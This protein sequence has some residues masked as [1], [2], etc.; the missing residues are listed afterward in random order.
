MVEA[1]RKR[2]EELLL[3]VVMVAFNGI[4]SQI[5]IPWVGN[6]TRKTVFIALL[7]AESP[8]LNAGSTFWLQPWYTGHGKINL[9]FLA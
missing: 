5:R 8:T 1:L 4:L 7:D 3:V 2:N 6:L 9:L